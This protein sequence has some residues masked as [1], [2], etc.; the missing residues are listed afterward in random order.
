MPVVDEAATY[1]FQNKE[2]F[3]LIALAIGALGVF[4]FTKYIAMKEEQIEART[5]AIWY[6][7][8]RRQLGSEKIDQAIESFRKAT[9]ESPGDRTYSLA[10]ANALAAGNHVAEARETLLRL[11]E[12]GPED[13]E[14]N[15]QLARLD[16]KGGEIDDAIQYYQNA[17]YGRW[18]GTQADSRQRQLR[19][20][21]I[22]FLLEHQRRNFALSELLILETDLPRTAAAHLETARLFAQA[23]D[24]QH[25][26]GH[27]DE[28]IELDKNNVD[29][30]TEA[31]ETEFR[32]GDYRRTERYLEAAM[33]LSPQVEKSRHLLS[34]SEGVLSGDPLEQHLSRKES[35]E[36]LL[37]GLTQATQRLQYYLREPSNSQ[38][39]SQLGT[40]ESQARVLTSAL[41][42]RRPLDSE[43]IYSG[44]ELIYNI[45]RA[46]A[47][48]GLEPDVLDEA[49]LLIG[50][51]HGVAQP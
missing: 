5:A 29:A 2:I 48:A 14:I 30:L 28:A 38:R 37:R 42:S 39:S 18:A 6:S 11:R 36:R 31:G 8:G 22:R 3:L 34:I 13:A 44:V 21:L 32:L 7:E 24:A 26:L 47:T 16:V 45:E 40:L 19:I 35:R 25:A 17:L 51:K 9:A 49:L 46:T 4:A 41:H 23:G 43:S 1:R 15:S 12:S 20:E 10:L 33:R 50:Q 27:Y